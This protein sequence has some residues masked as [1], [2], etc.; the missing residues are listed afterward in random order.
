MRLPL[1]AVIPEPGLCCPPSCRPSQNSRCIRMLAGVCLCHNRPP[2]PG[3]TR[4]AAPSCIGTVLELDAPHI[5]VFDRQMRTYPPHG[6]TPDHDMH[7]SHV[8]P[9]HHATP[10][11]VAVRHSTAPGPSEPSHLRER[12]IPGR[13]CHA[14]RVGCSPVALYGDNLICRK[15]PPGD[16][17]SRYPLNRRAVRTGQQGQLLG[18]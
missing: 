15:G 12:F 4:T 2:R 17:T 7:A 3:A 1:P 5:Q 11:H 6:N 14:G 16:M 13:I 8:C 18:S 9:P 10:R